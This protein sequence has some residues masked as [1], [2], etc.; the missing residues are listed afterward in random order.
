MAITQTKNVAGST[1]SRDAQF[2]R[3]AEAAACTIV[4]VSDDHSIAY[5]NPFAQETTGHSL[6][7]ACGKDFFDVF[8]PEADRVFARKQFG[9]AAAG[10]LIDGLEM[11]VRCSDGSLR[12]KVW[13]V[14]RLPGEQDRLLAVGQSI[15]ALKEAGEEAVRAGRLAA[16]GEMVAGV[17][18]ESRNALQEAQ[19]CAE[20]L[21]LKLGRAHQAQ[22]LLTDLERAHDRLRRLFDDL[23]GYAGPLQ[24]QR[25]CCN[26]A[27]VWREAWA[28]LGPTREGRETCLQ[29]ELASSTTQIH[30][31]PFR[32][33]QALRNILVNSL[34]SCTDPVRITIRCEDASIDHRSA[35]CLRIR[36]NGPGI[37]R[38]TRRKVFE[39]FYSTRSQGTGLGMAIAKR[40]VEA[41]KGQ[42]ALSANHPPGAEFVLTLP[43]GDS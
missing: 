19:A 18:H 33:T 8:V 13:N 7:A 25:C 32:L 37:P 27:E 9:R 6:D 40:I 22:A 35:V 16:I 15:A 28:Q 14:R 34:R 11:S 20:L 17:A 42:I 31:D 41:H 10:E 43:R 36:D 23:G 38:E 39:P 4:V 29:E 5:L 30:A 24:L 21:G 2:G 26:V 1:G 3:L 12:S